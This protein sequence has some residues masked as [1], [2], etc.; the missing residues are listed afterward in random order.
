M[1]DTAPVRAR[2]PDFAGLL[3]AGED[4]VPFSALRRAESIG[5]PLGNAA[6]LGQL[7]KLTGRS[8]RPRKRGPKPKQSG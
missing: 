6:F 3:A 5:R 8:L 1:T 2:Y 4:E 7:E